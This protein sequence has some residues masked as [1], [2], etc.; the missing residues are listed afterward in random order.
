MV[1]KLLLAAALALSSL[2]AT[3]ASADF[4]VLVPSGSEGDWTSP[5]RPTTRR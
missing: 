4:T 2:V 5:L 3:E 1:R